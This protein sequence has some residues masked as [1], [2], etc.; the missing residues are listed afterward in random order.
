MTRLPSPTESANRGHPACGW[1]PAP[2]AHRL[3]ASL[4]QSVCRRRP[5]GRH[6]A[7]IAWGHSLPPAPSSPHTPPAGSP[8]GPILTLSTVPGPCGPLGFG[9]LG[10]LPQPQRTP[11][12]ESNTRGD[13]AS[14]KGWAF[15][16]CAQ[17]GRARRRSDSG[18][19][20]RHSTSPAEPG[21]P[22]AVSPPGFPCEQHW[23]DSKSLD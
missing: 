1:H 23:R 18:H 16:T 3:S 22:Q 21:C 15:A 9:V 10:H 14:S 6:R 20:G 2:A 13:W 12:G 4:H 8:P 17:V 19:L 11:R 7:A 5:Q